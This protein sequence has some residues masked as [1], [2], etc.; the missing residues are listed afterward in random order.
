MM[1]QVTARWPRGWLEV[2]T[3]RAASGHVEVALVSAW[4]WPVIPRSPWGQLEVSL[5]FLLMLFRGYVQ[6]CLEVS[7]EFVFGWAGAHLEVSI[8]QQSVHSVDFDSPVWPLFSQ[9]HNLDRQAIC[10]AFGSGCHGS[11]AQQCPAGCLGP[12]WKTFI[13]TKPLCGLILASGNGPPAW[14]PLSSACGYLCHPSCL[15]WFH[16]FWRTFGAAGCVPSVMSQPQ[17]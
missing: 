9:V 6:V 3:L 15:L 7:L 4:S 8:L 5:K 13:E 12:R 17:K 14:A 11:K 2:V 1:P 16:G 10:F